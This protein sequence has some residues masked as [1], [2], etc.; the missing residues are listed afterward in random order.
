MTKNKNKCDCMILNLWACCNY[1]A[2]MT[3]WGVQCLLESLNKSAKVINYF[4]R[5]Q[6]KNIYKNSFFEKFAN[7]HLNLTSEVK[8]YK[9]FKNLNKQT[10]VFI[11]GS[12][13]VWNSQIIKNHCENVT[14]GIYLL[15]FVN[16]NKKKLSYSASFGTEYFNDTSEEKKLFSY[17]L[18]RF[19]GISVRE[20]NGVSIVNEISDKDA[21]QLIDGAFCIP[22][23]KLNELITISQNQEKY[24]G[25]F[26]LPYFKQKEKYEKQIKLYSEKLNIPVR[27]L[28]FS[29]MTSVNEWLTF[30]KNAE[31]IFTDSYHATIFSIIFNKPFIQI[32]NAPTQNRFQSLYRLL[33]ITSKPFIDESNLNI[34]IENIVNSFDWENI[35]EKINSEVSKAKKWMEEQLENKKKYTPPFDN[36]VTDL[37][38]KKQILKKKNPINKKKIIKSIKL[39]KMI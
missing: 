28:P 35:N 26:L 16:S 14:E 11:A 38:I 7:S 2:I 21:V 19:D 37:H 22:K 30:I 3:C 15:D 20:D 33:N 32:I 25:V 13:Q 8:N 9:D 10:N 18:K 5:N 17:Y 39:L 1:G 4:P 12:D 27:S 29:S 31:I 34:D 24:I 36:L 6:F 23:E